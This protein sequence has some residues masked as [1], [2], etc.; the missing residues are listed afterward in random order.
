MN[1]NRILIQGIGNEILTDDG[2]GPKIV[3]RLQG[4]LSKRILTLVQLTPGDLNY[5]IIFR[6]MI[7]LFLLML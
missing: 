6:A 2:I 1:R 4:S 5:W 3:K 7:L